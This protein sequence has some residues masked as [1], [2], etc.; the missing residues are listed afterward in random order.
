MLNR[1][2]PAFVDFLLTKGPAQPTDED[3]QRIKVGVIFK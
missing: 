2:P 1:L 3:I